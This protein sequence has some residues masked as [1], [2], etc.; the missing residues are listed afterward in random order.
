MKLTGKI[1][2]RLEESLRIILT[3]EQRVI[4]LYRYGYEP[5]RY[6]WEEDDFVYGINTVVKQYPDHRPK[7]EILPE[8]LKEDFLDGEPF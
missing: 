3:P 8:S 1:L 5:K 6:Q 4:L 2:T 7:K